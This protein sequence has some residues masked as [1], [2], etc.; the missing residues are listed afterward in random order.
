M[1]RVFQV[2]VSFC[3]RIK[4]LRRNYP[5][6]E[7]DSLMQLLQPRHIENVI[8]LPIFARRWVAVNLLS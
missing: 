2:I 4:L 3:D 6:Q 5:W 1:A 8:F 7:S